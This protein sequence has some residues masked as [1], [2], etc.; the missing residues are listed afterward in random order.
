MKKIT[1]F[2]GIKALAALFGG[3]LLIGFASTNISLRQAQF[4]FTFSAG[5]LPSSAYFG[6]QID[7][8]PAY[9]PQS[10]CSPTPKPGVVAFRSMVLK[11]F[12][13]TGDD[14]ITRGCNDGGT[15]EHKEGRAWDWK[16][17]VN[18]PE[19]VAAVNTLFAWL[20]ATDQYG[21]QF[22]MARRLGIMY[23]IWNH[24]IWGAYNAAEGWRPYTGT[25]NPHTDHV[26]FSFYWIG[27][28]Q[29]TSFWRYVQSCQ[30]ATPCL[31]TG[32]GSPTNGD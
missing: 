27:A 21:H 29:Q 19:D 13:K 10:T 12:P 30:G 7:P 4:S 16:V 25:P 6:S 8:V 9:E 24:R 23:I 14:G 22:A 20:F 1:A 5:Q 28:N 17:S 18:N 31:P 3:T 11:V 2:L 32:S 26:H 15:S